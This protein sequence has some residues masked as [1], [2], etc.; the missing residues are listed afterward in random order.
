[1]HPANTTNDLRTLKTL[2]PTKFEQV[3]KY[4]KD[5]KDSIIESVTEK[6]AQLYV[7]CFSKQTRQSMLQEQLNTM[8]YSPDLQ[9]WIQ[10]YWEVKEQTDLSE[11]EASKLTSKLKDLL[12]AK[13]QEQSAEVSISIDHLEYSQGVLGKAISRAHLKKKWPTIYDCLLFDQN[14]KAVLVLMKECK[15]LKVKIY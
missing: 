3:F 7:A 5:S 11:R 8:G 1:M 14:R 6:I 12:L 9:K 4:D 13:L 10:G 15:R 2:P